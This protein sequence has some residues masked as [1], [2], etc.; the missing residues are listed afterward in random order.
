V[1]ASYE[2]HLQVRTPRVRLPSGAV[3]LM[4]PDFAGRLN[5]FTLLF[6][7]KRSISRPCGVERRLTAYV[8]T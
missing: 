5:G 8:P 3:R 1:E 7:G 2:C 6:E 4:E